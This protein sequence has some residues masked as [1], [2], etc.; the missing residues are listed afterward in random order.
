MSDILNKMAQD[1]K[2]EF[3][4]EKKM[5][6]SI[7]E[8]TEET[9]I[10][11]PEDDEEEEEVVI[12]VSMPSENNSSIEVSDDEIFDE[13]EFVITDEELNEVMPDLDE[14]MIQEK[15][16]KVRN[17][18]VAFR[19]NLFI[20]KG[21][22]PEEADEA[23]RNRVKKLGEEENNAYLEEHPKLGIVEVDKRNVDK[24]EFTQEERE[25]LSKVRSIQLKV[26]EDME[27]KTIEIE[28]VDKK[29]KATVLQSIDSNLSQH[30][31]PLPLACDF[32]RFKGSQIIQLI[33]AVKYEDSTIDEMI[34]KKA[35]LIYNQLSLASNIEKYDENG[36][37]KMSY[38]D[39]TNKYLFHDMDMGLYAILVASSMESIDTELTCGS[40]GQPFTWSYN[41]KTLLNLDDLSDDF[42]DLFEDIL[43]HKSDKPYLNKLYEMKNKSVRV[44]SP[45]TQNIY[46]LNYPTIARAINLYQTIDQKDETM[47]YL[48]AF[49][50]FI[51]KLY[52]YNN[53]SGKYI[54]VDEDEQR[55]LFEVLQS[56]PQEEIDIIQKF[57]KPYMYAP[58]FVLKSKCP[59]CGFDM[60]NELSID[61]LVFLKARDSSTE[62]R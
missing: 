25:K 37:V 34:S 3:E 49:A 39:F 42:K 31:V 24:V 19:K 44:Q 51:D 41:L 29:N 30:S 36:K 10:N 5:E 59:S 1:A 57:L 28:K 7:E 43:A 53:N 20:R 48:S 9:S 13:D 58:K 60:Q 54:P 46:E 17:D 4:N 16:A 8:T 32:A 55:S 27:L 62:I 52:V 14:S 45:I 15:Y 47:I 61:D 2:N 22:T 56:I 33:Q 50:L 40:C 12:G 18:V 23:A 35:S 21:F 26:V 6:N 11:I 38:V